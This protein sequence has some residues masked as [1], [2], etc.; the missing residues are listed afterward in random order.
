MNDRANELLADIRE[1]TV[2][3]HDGELT[4]KDA[5]RLEMT[6]VMLRQIRA[7]GAPDHPIVEYVRQRYDGDWRHKVW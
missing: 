3:L 4:D 1:L 5:E 2:E 6:V 7:D